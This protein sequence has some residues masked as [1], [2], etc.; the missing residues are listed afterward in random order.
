VDIV[1]PVCERRLL[2]LDRELEDLQPGEYLA[3]CD[4]GAY[5]YAMASNYNNR[6][7]AGC[8]WT[9]TGMP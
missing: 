3:V 6:F 4:V 1:G 9:A 2:A 5:G 7:A 8:W